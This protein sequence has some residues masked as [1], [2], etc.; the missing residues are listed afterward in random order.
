MKIVLATGGFDPLH[1]GH[2]DYFYGAK[3]LGDELVVGINSE[4]WLI[5]KKGMYFMPTIERV[6]I[7]E[8]LKWVDRVITFDDRDGSANDAIRQ[9]LE[10]DKD[11]IV[12]FANGGDRKIGNIPEIEKYHSDNRVQFYFN[13]GGAKTNSSRQL[14]SRTIKPTY[15]RRASLLEDS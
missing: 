13:V 8:S 7:V 12:I 3:Q 1:C 11:A 5:R 10:H 2:L 15:E 14:L 6:K 4:D 9:C